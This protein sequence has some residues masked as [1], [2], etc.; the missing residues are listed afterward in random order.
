[1]LYKANVD[2]CSGN[3]QMECDQH[4]EFLNVKYDGV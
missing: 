4:V 3:T 2:V 1:M